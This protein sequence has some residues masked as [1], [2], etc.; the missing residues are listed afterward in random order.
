MT[1]KQRLDQRQ[2]QKLILAPALQQAIKLLPLTNLEL[3]E[4]ID[5]ELS[6]NPMIEIEDEARERKPKD[7]ETVAAEEAGVKNK[8]SLLEGLSLESTEPRMNGEPGRDNLLAGF[9]EYL[10]EGFRP[11]FTESRDAVSLE[12]TISRAASLWDH[13]NWQ[14][15]LTFFKAE[16]R[17]LAEKIIGDINEDGY[18]STTVEELARLNQTTPERIE[19]LRAKIRAFDPVG[20]GSLDLGEALLSQMDHLQVQDEV[21]R[22]IVAKHLPLL[23]RS[24]FAQLARVLGISL[25]EIRQ[26]IDLLKSLDPTPGRKYSEERTTYVVPD[27]FVT[28]EGDEWKVDLNDE[29]LPRLRISGY[30]R[31][32]LGK[33]A[34]GQPEAYNFL[35][36]RLKK[37]LWF[38]RSL[39]Q[40]NQTIHKVARFIVDRQKEF[41]EKG[42]D[43]IRP[44]TLMEIAQDIGVHEST[45]GRVVAN[46]YMMTPRGVFSLKYFFH[47][48]LQGSYGEDVSSLKV[49]DRLRKLVEAE[50]KDHPLSDIEIGDLLSREGLNIARR[51]VAK[52]RNQLKI[53][54][55]HI[56]KRKSAMEE[57][58]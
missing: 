49:K 43:Y 47:K 27:I 3:I 38:M 22:T 4:V 23:E 25:A 17:E 18:L 48:S 24:D 9:Q 46:K 45:V 39:D 13:L 57:T 5:E 2:V 31:Q 16:D 10:D 6:Q 42:I 15:S 32:L 29:G 44:L 28:K 33:A 51:T 26:R 20:C 12:N 14:A 53:E 50:D 36:D 40:R 21:V 19:S 34:E 7:S 56:R 35:K 55:S 54:P 37:A 58:T 30:Y 52:Y 11:H 8:D 41:F 1:L